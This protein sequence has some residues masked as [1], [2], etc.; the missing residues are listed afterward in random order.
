LILQKPLATATQDDLSFYTDGSAQQTAQT[1]ETSSPVNTDSQN[2][3]APA[4][5]QGLAQDKTQHVLHNLLL[6]EGLP[7]TTQIKEILP[8]AVYLAH[9]VA[10]IVA[11]VELDV[12]SDA[13]TALR[14]AGTPAQHLTVYAPWMRSDNFMQGI[15]TLAESLGYSADKLR[16]RG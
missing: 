4:S 3:N 5:P 14:Q 15:K 2:T 8:S 12:L 9:D 10:L 7:L 16:L 11:P 13:L 1:S 6:S